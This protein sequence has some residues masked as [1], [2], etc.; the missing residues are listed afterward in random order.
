M[1]GISGISAQSLQQTGSFAKVQPG[2]VAKQPGIVG[3]V[4]KQ[5]STM[6]NVQ[7][8]AASKQPGSVAKQ[9]GSIAKQQPGAV[10]KQP[11]TIAKQA[12]AKRPPP[13]P[14]AP[15]PEKCTSSLEPSRAFDVI[16]MILRL[17]QEREGVQAIS[18][19]QAWVEGDKLGR[20]L[21]KLGELG[22]CDR[23]EAIERLSMRG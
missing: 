18:Q 3:A 22:S 7:A 16:A 6:E 12:P 11:G 9:P 23:E 21:T 5:Q 17:V 4:A 8:G 20:V 13:A 14:P 10:A 2:S 1:G 19:I 15:E